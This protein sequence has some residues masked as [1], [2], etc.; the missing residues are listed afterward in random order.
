LELG[1]S[2]GQ[3]K[4]AYVLVDD[5]ERWDV[6]YQFA[7]GVF[8]TFEALR[9]RL[10]DARPVTWFDASIFDYDP[11]ERMLVQKPGT[12]GKPRV[13]SWGFIPAEGGRQ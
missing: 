11:V 10:V 5:P 7:T 3:G 4:T 2:I 12:E 1:V 6:M 9:R 13:Q 8:D